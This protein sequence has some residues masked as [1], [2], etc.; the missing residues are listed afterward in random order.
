M[1]FFEP[2]E[3]IP[4]NTKIDI[5]SKFYTLVKKAELLVINLAEKSWKGAALATLMALALLSAFDGSIIK[6]G[7]PAF[8]EFLIVALVFVLSIVGIGF[9]IKLLFGIFVK[10]NPYFVAVIGASFIVGSFLPGRF[11]T[12]TFLLVQLVCGAILAIAFAEGTNKKLRYF[13]ALF[14]LLINIVVFSFLFWDGSDQTVRVADKFW[15]QKQDT[16]NFEDPSKNGSFKVK[17]LFYG[18]GT[19]QN[20]IEFGQNVELKTKPVDATAFFNQ[21]EGLDN[22]IRKIYWGF[23][24]KNY[25]LNARVWVPEGE[26]NFPLVLIVHGNHI[27]TTNSDAGY[28]YLGKLLASRGFIVASIDENFLNASWYKDYNQNE[29]FARAWILLKHLENWRTWNQTKGNPFYQKVDMDNIALI[30][31]SRGGAAVAVASVINKLNKYHLDAKQEFNFNFSIKGIVQIA[32]NDTYSPQKEVQLKPENLD[33]LVIQGGFDHDI[34]KFLGSRVFNRV[35]FTDDKPHFKSAIY[36]YRANHGQFNTEWGRKDL[37][38][39]FSWLINLK[40]IM[41]AGEQRKIAQ[42]Y[43]SAFL[44]TCLHEKNEYLPLFKNHKNGKLILPK[45]FYINQFEN[46]KCKYI[47]DFQEDFDVN[48]ASLKGCTIES[49]NLKKWSENALTLRDESSLS[50]HTS[51]VFLAWNKEY[52]SENKT[53]HYSIIIDSLA[54]K[55]LNMGNPQNLIFSICK[56][57]DAVENID[58][59]IELVTKTTRV[60]KLFSD[61]MILPPTLKTKLSKWDFLHKFGNGKTV[62]YVLQ[63]VE[64]PFSEFVKTDKL[65]NTNEI[66]EIR[67]VFDKVNSGEIF[68]DKIGVE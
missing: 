18:S 58:F 13:I 51:G 37:R 3:N 43:I 36:I 42:I 6:S 39:P 29:V 14:V 59:T 34:F 22:F 48:T 26:G 54:L 33:Y 66:T 2:T 4:K 31:H 67:F 8:V 63:Y 1:N 68:L 41:E 30:G 5:K 40:P 65:F 16:V 50:Q 44:E 55:S 49:E 21:T 45:E 12:F 10:F 47:A 7:L 20:R 23:N 56:I 17:T 32:P 27:M 61:F 52:I 57:S 62:E 24:S 28:E 11:F 64:I 19:D 25:P 38:M 9:A 46:T 53:A 60:K 35:Q 15:Y